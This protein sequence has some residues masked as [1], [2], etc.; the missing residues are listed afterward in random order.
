MTVG[1]EEEE[2]EEEEK[3]EEM[4]RG[5]RRRAPEGPSLVHEKLYNKA[6]HSQ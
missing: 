5:R 3:E 6:Q 1:W 4:A 2:E